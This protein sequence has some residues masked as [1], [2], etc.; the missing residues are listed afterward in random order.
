MEEIAGIVQ[1]DSVKIERGKTYVGW[2]IKCYGDNAKEKAIK[3]DKELQI[4]YPLEK[5]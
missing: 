1:Q 2:T 3:L 5:S 4:E